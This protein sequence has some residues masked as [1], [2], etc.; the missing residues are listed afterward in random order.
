[1]SEK[2]ESMTEKKVSRRSMLKWT[3]ALAAA[4]AVGA[5]AGYGATELMKPPPTPPPSFK[6]PLSPEVQAR[7]DA[8]V[9]DLIARHQGETIAYWGAATMG[10]DYSDVVKVRIK[11]G[12]VT[13]IEPDDT[14]NP[15]ITIEDTD[16]NL[17]LK[18]M[19]KNRA[20]GRNYAGR[21]TWYHPNRILYPM[22]RVSPRGTLDGKFVRIS[23]D[24]ALSTVVDKMK[25]MKEKYGPYSIS[26]N[27]LAAW[28]GCGVVSW[29]VASWESHTF[30]R[31]YCLGTSQ[32]NTDLPSHFDAKLIVLWGVNTSDTQS[33]YESYYFTLAKEKGIPMINIS[34]RY[35][36]DA[37]I[38]ADQWIPIRTSTDAAMLL[39]MANV[40]L[41][42]N[43]YDKTFV[44]KFVW[45]VG[46]QKWKDYV[47]GVTDGVEKTPEW[48]EKIT[49]V[50]AQTTVELTRLVAKSKP[51][52]FVTGAGPGRM[53]QGYDFAW[54][55]MAVSALTGNIGIAGTNVCQGSNRAMTG[56]TIS[57][58]NP[59]AFYGQKAGKFKTPTCY[60]A[61]AF[62][63][64]VLLREKID[65]GEMAEDEYRQKVG[66]AKDDPISNM[67]MMFSRSRYSTETLC[68]MN[69]QV[70]M[71]KKMEF[72]VAR[73][74][75]MSP[76]ALTADV[77]LPWAEDGP[78][79]MMGYKSIL[80]GMMLSTKSV[81][82][83][84][85]TKDDTWMNVQLAKR[86]GFVDQY[87]PGYTTDDKWDELLE[88]YNKQ[89]YEAW[90]ASETIKA[91][92]P[93]SWEDFTKTPVF[94]APWGDPAIAYSAQIQKGQKF[95]TP[96][97]KI[98]FYSET[99]AKGPDYLKDTRY[100][101]YVDPMPMYTG[102]VEGFGDPDPKL[103]QYPITTSSSHRRYHLHHRWDFNPLLRDE[104]YRH[105]IWLSVADAASRGI[106]DGDTVLVSNSTGQLTVPAYVTSRMTPGCAV[107][108][109]AAHSDVNQLGIDRRGCVNMV[110]TSNRD[111]AGMFP[112]CARV[113][114]SKF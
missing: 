83:P 103:I 6:P 89:A 40:L 13:A 36:I 44:D 50:P 31:S 76:T 12:L 46:F 34:P 85:E 28:Q 8:I 113:E 30:A 79:Q 73:V 81:A 88:G 24:E 11:D 42:E 65:T 84:G 25:T 35:G 104:V 82:W 112:Y 70:E 95:T 61:A 7:R 60:H 9:K 43:L 22:K 1:L 67:K 102:V 72:V 75:E 55:G 106:K 52:L 71:I 4:A 98:E 92:N 110:I 64:A 23:W 3:G 18:G 10:G 78:E 69:K 101:G 93:P 90:A 94:R 47:M 26:Y 68:D 29:G 38:M 86:L 20:L 17:I 100:G 14:V 53:N 107:I 56:S 57:K 49:G 5:V 15:D 105:S 66:A 58:P 74:S 59:G 48:A 27:P 37:E 51:C 33:A 108:F 63:D 77:I 80:A 114:V 99:L 2:K 109:E 96:S 39:A 32:Q 87:F 54:A 16:Q 97:G 91:L 45:D 41:K 19:I 62:M 21:A 111:F